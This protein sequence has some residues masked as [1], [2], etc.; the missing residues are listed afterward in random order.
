MKSKQI[1]NGIRRKQRGGATATAA[2]AAVAETVEETIKKANDFLESS[3]DFES[4][5]FQSLLKIIKTAIDIRSN[6]FNKM[7][8]LSSP[9]DSLTETFIS[10]NEFLAGNLEEAIINNTSAT[11]EIPE[12][13]IDNS[14]MV[15]KV[16]SFN[17]ES[18]DLDIYTYKNIVKVFTELTEKY[19]FSID[20]IK[21]LIISQGNF[22]I[23]TFDTLENKNLFISKVSD[24]LIHTNW[25]DTIKTAAAEGGARRRRRR[26]SSSRKKKSRRKTRRKV[27]RRKSRRKS[28]RKKKS[29]RKSRR[30]SS[31]KKKSRRKSSRKRKSRRRSRKKVDDDED[32]K[33]KRRS[34]RKS[35]R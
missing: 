25:R 33:P 32:E 10:V 11:K 14:I 12:E 6:L 15:T 21:Q 9:S 30:K 8:D 22:W 31:R 16:D 3:K 35:R 34:R 4:Q 7:K 23:F 2:A 29:R 18:L 20:N 17:F 27:S 1:Q 19:D 24:E 13:D 28:S 26:K 5:T